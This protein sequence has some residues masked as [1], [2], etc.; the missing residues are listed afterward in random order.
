MEEGLKQENFSY[1]YHIF[2]EELRERI[3]GLLV[4]A[5]ETLIEPPKQKEAVF[6]RL[7]NL[8]NVPVEESY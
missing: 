7:R 1:L 3:R 6:E 8:K 5:Y 4:D 2:D